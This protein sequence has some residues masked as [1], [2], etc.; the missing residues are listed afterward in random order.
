MPKQTT[1]NADSENRTYR[2][3]DGKLKLDEARRAIEGGQR[4]VVAADLMTEQPASVHE[5]QTIRQALE[6]LQRLDVRH[7]PVVSG[8]GELVGMLSDRDIRSLPLV[9]EAQS[10]D[11]VHLDSPITDVMSS[12][13]LSVDPETP[14]REI[15]EIMLDNKI[16]A[17]PVITSDGSLVGIVSY[18]DFLRELEGNL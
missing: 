2:K 8:A 14:A 1:A 16:G 13:V 3:P 9:Y 15:V 10:G 12:D 6:L 18:V 17:V 4:G 5:G 7:L 11:H